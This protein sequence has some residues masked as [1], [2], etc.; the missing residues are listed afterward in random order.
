MEINKNNELIKPISFITNKKSIELTIEDSPITMINKDNQLMNEMINNDEEI[1]LNN[2]EEKNEVRSKIEICTNKNN[3]SN[4]EGKLECPIKVFWDIVVGENGHL[5]LNTPNGQLDICNFDVKVEKIIIEDDGIEK[6]EKYKLRCILQNPMEKYGIEEEII[7]LKRGDLKESDWIK[8]KLGIKYYIG[9]D[10][11]AYKYLDRYISESAKFIKEEIEYKQ[12]GWRNINGRYVYLHGRGAI[13]SNE[14]NIHGD[15]EYCINIKNYKKED[16]L[17]YSLLLTKIC[18]NDE[19]SIF[20]FVYSHLSVLKELFSLAGAEPKFVLW[21]YGLTG[22]MKT[23]VSKIFFNLFNRGKDMK[24]S[25]TFKDTQAALELKAF[26]HKD[27]SLLIDDY[28]PSSSYIEKKDMESKASNILRMY[29]DGISKGRSNKYMQKQ[30]VYPP[31]GLCVITGE[32]FIGGESTIARYVGIEVNREEFDK[33][34]LS[35]HQENPLIFSTYM[36]YFIEWVSYNFEDIRSYIEINFSNIRNNFSNEFNHPRLGEVYSIL[37]I[38]IDIIFRYFECSN[39]SSKILKK[40]EWLFK[41][42]NVIREHEKNNFNE[43]PAVMYLI[44]LK[45]LIC[46]GQVKLNSIKEDNKNNYFIG[47]KDE[48]KYYLL[49]KIAFE[50]IKKFWKGQGVEFP[51]GETAVNKALEKINA[52]EVSKEISSGKETIRRT[53]KIKIGNKSIRVLVVYKSIYNKLDS[54]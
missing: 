21:I 50:K 16:I 41:I 40:E 26:E 1:N 19:K 52:I 24:I 48:E 27:C 14:I 44:A 53:K 34:I 51:V 2:Y 42:T 25:A 7:I 31:R 46:S 33:K 17:K 8:E 9:A 36:N 47:Y 3:Y 29:G 49:P 18:R 22:S 28:H 6:K 35:F 45:E 32:D 15:K 43:D 54:I 39:Y 10:C 13:G 23:S 4:N 12:V 5:Y 30:K 11:N 38:T 20:M 37:N